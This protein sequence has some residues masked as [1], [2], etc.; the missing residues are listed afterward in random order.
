MRVD[1][2]LWS[3]RYFKTRSKA[4]DGAKKGRIRVNGDIVK[5]SRDV[6]PSDMIEVRLD[7]ITYAIEVLDLPA[8]RVG[9]K[10]VALYCADR[11]P[12]ERFEA[13]DLVR[14]NQDY[15]RRRG[16]GRPTKKDRRELGDVLGSSTD[17]EEE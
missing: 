12:K 11:T 2:Y 4:T 10:L 9:P 14:L 3:I 5:P 6:Y 13:R 15:Y 17:E 8:S 1:K 7:Q 16:E